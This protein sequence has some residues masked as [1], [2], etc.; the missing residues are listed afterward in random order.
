MSVSD[1]TLL[2][3]LPAGSHACWVFTE[4]DAHGQM[5]TR[6]LADAAGLGQKTA[7]F[8]PTTSPVFR[9]LGPLAGLAADPYQAFLHHGR[10]DAKAMFAMFRDQAALAQRQG[11][12]GLRVVADMDWLAPAHVP[13]ETMVAFEVLLDRV[14]AEMGAT[15]VC[16]YRRSTFPAEAIVGTLSVHPLRCGHG[17]DPPFSLMATRDGEWRLSGEI[18]LGGRSVFA[19]AF[20]AMTESPQLVVDVGE[21]EFI[22]I[23]GIR[24]IAE[25]AHLGRQRIQLRGVGPLF[26]QVWT[27]AGFDQ[28]APTVELL[29]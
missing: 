20:R 14:V 25:V 27:I 4:D 1:V 26:E 28:L 24:T 29:A 21:L 17:Q 22:D 16:A 3:S 5:V 2:E 9:E 7:L 18:D 11:Y 23:V 6:L 12:E 8:G 19:A 13:V 10:F 15:I